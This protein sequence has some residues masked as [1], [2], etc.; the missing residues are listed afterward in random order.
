MGFTGSGVATQMDRLVIGYVGGGR[1]IA[2]IAPTEGAEYSSLTI[3][4]REFAPVFVEEGQMYD[5]YEDEDGEIAGLELHTVPNDAIHQTAAQLGLID[6]SVSPFPRWPL[7]AMKG[8]GL[9]I[10]AFG[11]VLVFRL[12]EDYLVSV[13]LDE[14]LTPSQADSIRRAADSV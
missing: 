4:G 10:E 1:R 11:G 6:P 13:L 2:L 12:Q 14:W 9:G 8:K 7:R 5:S 3:S